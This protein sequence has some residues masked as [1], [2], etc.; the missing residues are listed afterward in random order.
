MEKYSYRWEHLPNQASGITHL[1][2]EELDEKIFLAEQSYGPLRAKKWG[3]DRRR[4]A[5]ALLIERWNGQ[6]PSIWRYTLLPEETI[7]TTRNS[8]EHGRYQANPH[9]RC[10]Y[11]GRCVA[12]MLDPYTKAC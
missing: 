8:T 1:S 10:S 12:N 9:A 6:S 7:E 5:L 3:P 2:P 11:Y 4:D